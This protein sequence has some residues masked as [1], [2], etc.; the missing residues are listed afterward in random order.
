MLTFKLVKCRKPHRCDLCNKP[1]EKGERAIYSV[2]FVWDATS[3]AG[4]WYYHV[5]CFLSIGYR[6]WDGSLATW[7]SM[8]PSWKR[9]VIEK[10]GLKELE[11]ELCRAI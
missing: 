4:R 10:S 8:E 3:E 1:I 5:K 9:Y 2:D 11:G 7:D 6:R